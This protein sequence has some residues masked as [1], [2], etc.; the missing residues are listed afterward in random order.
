M[1]VEME[2]PAAAAPSA[3]AKAADGG[4]VADV[5]KTAPASI[6]GLDDE[7]QDSSS[8]RAGREGEEGFIPER[9]I[10][11]CGGDRVEAA[12]R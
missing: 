11:G 9:Y 1:S 12:K 2:D 8:S 3:G 6:A 5:V 10:V 4:G 7:E